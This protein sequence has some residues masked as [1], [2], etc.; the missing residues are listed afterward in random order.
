MLWLSKADLE[1]E[2]PPSRKEMFWALA[3]TPLLLLQ[4]I[5]W[6]W[7]LFQGLRGEPLPISNWRGIEVLR[8]GSS[9]HFAAGVALYLVLIAVA[10]L[11]LWAC[12]LQFQCWSYWRG[13]ARPVGHR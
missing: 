4:I 5:A 13:R 3:A 11:L 12:A 2:G 10:L 8:T 1:E 6:S 9:W 7:R